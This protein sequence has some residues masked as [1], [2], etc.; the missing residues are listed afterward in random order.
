MQWYE[1]QQSRKGVV[2]L[3]IDHAK[4]KKY[5]ADTD[6]YVIRATE[7]GVPI[8]PEVTAKRIEARAVLNG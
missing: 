7:T 5:L 8:P 6:W 2:N 4:V 1:K 3:T